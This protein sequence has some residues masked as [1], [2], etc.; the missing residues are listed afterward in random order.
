MYKKDLKQVG[1]ITKNIAEN[2]QLSEYEN[3]P[4]MQ[5][6]DL[7]VHITKHIKDF[8]SVDN[9]MN[10]LEN[11][12]NVL[13]TPEFTYYD[14]EKKTILYYGI[15]SEYVCYVV[16]LNISRDYCYLASLYPISRKKLEKYKEKSYLQQE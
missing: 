5:S 10:A 16:K 1:K 14:K 8:K 12:P 3:R 11:I 6:L 4:I 13:K 15:T 7:Y 9:Y 2:H